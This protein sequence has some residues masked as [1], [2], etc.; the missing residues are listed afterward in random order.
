MKGKILG[1]DS[2][3]NEGAI[4]GTD[5]NRYTF[6][7]TEWKGGE[8][9]KEEIPVDFVPNEGCALKIY[10]IKDTKAEESKFVI[11]GPWGTH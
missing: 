10:P 7:L 4:K 8:A 11:S 5:G 6:Q 2:N 3:S 1:Y 9:Q